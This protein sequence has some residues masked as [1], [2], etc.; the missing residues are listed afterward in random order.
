M[1]IR[2]RWKLDDEFGSSLLLSV[3]EGTEPADN[4]DGVLLGVRRGLSFFIISH[5]WDIVGSLRTYQESKQKRQE[6]G[7]SEK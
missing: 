2:A 4:L 5:A 7:L 3:I 1:I 6:H